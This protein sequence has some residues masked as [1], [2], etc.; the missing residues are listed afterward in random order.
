MTKMMRKKELSDWR[1]NRSKDKKYKC[2]HIPVKPRQERWLRERGAAASKAKKAHDL[3]KQPYPHVWC[4]SKPRSHPQNLLKCALPS[5]SL[6]TL[7]CTWRPSKKHMPRLLTVMH[8]FGSKVIQMRVR[9][10]LSIRKPSDKCFHA[11]KP[12]SNNLWQPLVPWLLYPL[13]QKPPSPCQT[14]HT[15]QHLYDLYSTKSKH[16]YQ[17]YEFLTKEKLQACKMEW[18]STYCS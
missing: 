16:Y 14:E 2:S 11:W 1:K 13:N 15:I 18:S 6:F 9:H 17:Y 7:R 3:E 12:T 5:F 10:T 8:T 4:G